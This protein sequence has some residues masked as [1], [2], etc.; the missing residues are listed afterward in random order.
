MGR[1][2][3]WIFMALLQIVP[4]CLSAQT[5]HGPTDNPAADKNIPVFFEKVYLH[6]DRDKYLQGEDIWFKAYMLN[7][8]NNALINYSH[9]L[10]VEL[11]NPAAKIVLRKMLRLEN[12]LANGDFKLADS[13][14]AGNYRIRAYTNWMRNF[15][16]NFI[17]E[18][19]IRILNTGPVPVTAMLASNGKISPATTLVKDTLP[20]VRFFAEGGSLVNGVSSVVAVKAE[21]AIGYGMAASGQITSNSGIAIGNFSC[22]SLGFGA[23]VITP[24]AGQHYQA[25]VSI[26]GRQY[27]F[28]LPEAL[29]S[30]FNLALTHLTD[31]LITT[32][33]CN[34]ATFM[35]KNGQHLYLTAKHG[36]KTYISK[37]ITV[38][39]AVT[40]I[41]IP[42][43]LLPEGVVCVTIADENKQP[44]AERL[45]YVHHLN[46]IQTAVQTNKLIYD[47]KEKTIVNIKLNKPVVAHLSLAA[48]D[49]V[50]AP[51]Q[52]ADIQSY[53]NLQSEIKGKIEQPGRYFDT[54]NINRFKQL[55]L[56]LL[57]QG[58]RSFV[59]K[60]LEDTTLTFTR[61]V[62]QDITITG[63][64]RKLWAD[65]P[66]KDIHIDMHIPK[67]EGVKFFEA[68]T[69]S[70]GRFAIHGPVFYGYQYLYISSRNFDTKNKGKSNSGG[71]L[72]VDSLTRDTLPVYA[73]NRLIKD[74]TLSTPEMFR[75]LNIPKKQQLKEV[76]IKAK[77][78]R[79]FP[80]E[81]HPITLADQKDYNTVS[82]YLPYNIQG[83]HFKLT[84]YGE[85]T[86]IDGNFPP[87]PIGVSYQNAD[88]SA[89]NRYVARYQDPLDLPMSNVISVV[90]NKFVTINGYITY[91]VTLR[92]RPGAFDMKDYLDNTTADMVG[93][94]KARVF[95]TPK[96]GNMDNTPDPRTNT[97][98]WQPNIVTNANGEASISFYNTDRKSNV[99]LL[100]QGVTDSG[101][102]VSATAG[103]AVK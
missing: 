52:A 13:L 14:P 20:V 6:T 8:Q 3:F 25:K 81:V 76:N 99:R 56:L 93:Y 98:H 18:K 85:R 78:S 71:W 30:G 29:V 84:I 64:V 88:G 36:G 17:F 69:D 50:L 63:R 42:D 96:L 26:R 86:L 2:R 35:Q 55:D 79:K 44:L 67:A 74:T 83:V 87:L 46:G 31:T 89:I 75:L 49:A 73:V 92:L 77:L 61:E 62:E 16:D 7:A 102:P 10:Y 34:A 27:T 32:I 45:I 37:A 1:L 57:T 60:R 100:I 70:A 12:G 11:I 51:V 54:T 24:D 9:N 80:P 97:I 47:V 23:F 5:L 95:Y 94:A 38:N 21:D 22:D 101:E 72:K 33:S 15:G 28:P 90:V 58:W 103:Y 82:Q 91:H 65:K 53:L 43:P 68:N 4:L 66:L 19:N 59:W 39:S 40:C 41:N 48:I